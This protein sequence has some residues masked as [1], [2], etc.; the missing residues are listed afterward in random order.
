MLDRFHFDSYTRARAPKGRLLAIFMV[1]YTP[2]NLITV[3][4]EPLQE[5][6]PLLIESRSGLRVLWGDLNPILIVLVIVLMPSWSWWH[7]LP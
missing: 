1:A 4:D 5:F 3:L 7:V 6:Y 2:S